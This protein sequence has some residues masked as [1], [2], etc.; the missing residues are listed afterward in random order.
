MQ[1]VISGTQQPAMR[2]LSVAQQAALRGLI[3]DT[4]MDAG[5]APRSTKPQSRSARS[6]SVEPTTPQPLHPTHAGPQWPDDDEV[7]LSDTRVMRGLGI[8]R[9]KLFA[10]I[11]GGQLKPVRGLGRKLKFRAQDVFALIA[12]LTEAA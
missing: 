1:S 7:L 12:A 11:E 10:L 3:L 9:T 4:L 6:G 5:Y 8:G 2:A